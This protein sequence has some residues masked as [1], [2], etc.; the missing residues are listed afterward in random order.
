ME[1]IIAVIG[2]LF[3]LFKFLGEKADSKTYNETY[4]KTRQ[5][6]LDSFDVW[7]KLVV[8][9]DL[10][11]MCEKAA[12]ILISGEEDDAKRKRM[13]SLGKDFLE[14]FDRLPDELRRGIGED[15]GLAV[16][17]IMAHFGK[18]PYKMACDGRVCRVYNPDNPRGWP[19]DEK[20]WWN[21]HR[22]YIMIDRILREHMG[23]HVYHPLMCDY[24]PKKGDAFYKEGATWNKLEKR[25]P[26]EVQ[27]PTCILYYWHP[28][29]L[30]RTSSI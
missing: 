12:H 17:A 11:E 10:E 24:Y 5:D 9:H 4:R 19:D 28:G 22:C 3:Y 2:V 23:T 13:E 26:V 6:D 21:R 7:I 8:D 25:N 30:F 14:V 1:L 29:M 16:T 27:S 15:M 18:L 20:R